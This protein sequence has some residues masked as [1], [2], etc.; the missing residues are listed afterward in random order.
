[1]GI[2]RSMKGYVGQSGLPITADSEATDDRDSRSS[3]VEF[4]AE[5]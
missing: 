5:V 3:R 1:L 4:G 2:L